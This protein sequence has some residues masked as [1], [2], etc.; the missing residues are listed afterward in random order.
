MK[1]KF[2]VVVGIMMGVFFLLAG[3]G[4][5][6]D[7][8]VSMSEWTEIVQ[9]MGDKGSINWS[10]GYIEAIGIGAPPQKLIGTPRSVPWL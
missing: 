6:D 1:S 10:A 4:F 8:K 7:E 5:C 9:K 2:T 3:I